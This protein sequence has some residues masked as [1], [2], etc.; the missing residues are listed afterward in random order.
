MYFKTD[1][2]R[3]DIT[4]RTM[5]YVFESDKEIK[6]YYDSTDKIYDNKTGKVIKD[7]IE[8]LNINNKPDSIDPIYT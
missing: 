6:F 7:K 5:R 2:E 8:V 4:Y 1:G 3:Y